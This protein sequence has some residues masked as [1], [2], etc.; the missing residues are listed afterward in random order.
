MSDIVEILR[1]MQQDKECPMLVH[2]ALSEAI[3]EI[4]QLR[5][6]VSELESSPLAEEAL[7]I[8]RSECAALRKDAE[9]FR[10]LARNGTFGLSGAPGWSGVIRFQLVE[11]DSRNMPEAI[12]AAMEATY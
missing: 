6:Q 3:R 5:E 1:K 11:Q 9:R 7:D 8:L 2:M 12:D 10:W 4:E